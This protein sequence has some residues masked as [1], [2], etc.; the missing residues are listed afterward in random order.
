MTGTSRFRSRRGRPPLERPQT[1][2]G[3]P[4]LIL[5]RAHGETAETLDLC[6][7]RGI[8][9]PS[10]HRYGLRFRWLY[11]L[12]Y[13]APSVSAFDIS[14]PAG[15]PSSARP[16]DPQWRLTREAEYHHAATHLKSTGCYVPVMQYCVYNERALFA[17]RSQLHAAFNNPVL[18][19]RLEYERCLFQKGLYELEQLWKS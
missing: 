11:T 5:K 8:I 13:G 6:L 7:E 9:T 14:D 4:E 16:D 10:Q 18:A 12:R 19:R 1:D 15:G 2:L 3:T 17:N